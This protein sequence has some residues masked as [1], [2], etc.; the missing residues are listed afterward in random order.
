[1]FLSPLFLGLSSILSGVLQYF[2]RFFIYSLAPI[3]YNLG[4][5]F[6][7]LFLVPQ[8]GL[9]G[10]AWGV[11]LGALLHFLIQLPSTIYSGFELG[12]NFRLHQGIKDIIKL[13]V[14]RTIGLAGFQIN[15]VVITAL[16]SSLAIGSV[17]IFNLAHNL[18][19]VPIGIIGI[20]FAMAVFPSLASS[21]A[22]GDWQ[23]FSDNFSSVFNQVLY[24]VLP[25]SV[26]FFVLRAQ[27]VRLILG[28]GQFGWA[29][30]RLTAAALGIFS[31]SVFAQGLI[32]LISR[33]FYSSQ[34]TKTPVS[35][36]LIS[37]GLNI[38]LSFGLVWILNNHNFI[39]QF[40]TEIFRMQG[41]KRFAVL[42][43]PM[44]FS[45]SSIFNFAVLLKYFN[46]KIRQRDGGV[47]LSSAYKIIIS[48]AVM[49]ITIYGSLQILDFLF[50]THKFLDLLIQSGIATIVG[51]IFYFLTS[52]ILKAPEPQALLYKLIHPKS[53]QPLPQDNEPE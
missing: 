48:C 50:D 9:V 1:M 33:A 46:K 11:V 37:I 22:T 5:I 49:A 12:L 23:K 27:I 43:L 3:F 14:P 31:L 45:L 19:Y 40:F 29:D 16:A 41:I 7:I 25:I 35:I 17:A 15:Y 26:I 36:G 47:I 51:I 20:S 24:L 44:A 18:Q 42:G 28:T 4:I 30:T 34:D 10:L 21:Y 8:M 6:G 53:I 38:G 39:S 32:P 52:M 13:T 2:H